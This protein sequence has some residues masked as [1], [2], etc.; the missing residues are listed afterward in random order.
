MYLSDGGIVVEVSD[1]GVAIFLGGLGQLNRFGKR[2]QLMHAPRVSGVISSLTV[3]RKGLFIPVIIM[4]TLHFNQKLRLYATCLLG[5]ASWFYFT[6][7][8]SFKLLTQAETPSMYM[9]NVM[10]SVLAYYHRLLMPLLCSSDRRLDARNLQ[11]WQIWT[12]RNLHTLLGAQQ[13]FRHELATK[14]AFLINSKTKKV[15][16]IDGRTVWS[17]GGHWVQTACNHTIWNH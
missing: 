7:V 13:T 16:I 9:Y 1:G 14:Y 3:V 6:H 2:T 10:A 17:W 8:N 12:M 15:V 4:K 5:V 11:L